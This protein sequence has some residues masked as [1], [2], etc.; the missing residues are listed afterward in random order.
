MELTQTDITNLLKILDNQTIAINN[1]SKRLIEAEILISSI[2]DVVLEKNIIA[3]EDLLEMMTVK[4]DVIN[5][6]L[7]IEEKRKQKNSEL[8][9][10]TMIESYPYFGEPG[11]A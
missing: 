11:E 6:K 2:T 4:I 9:S 10:E 3:N 7:K 5:T 1:L 8:D